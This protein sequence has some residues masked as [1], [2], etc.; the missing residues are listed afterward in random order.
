MKNRK[1]TYE[2]VLQQNNGYGWD[3]VEYFETNA[4]FGGLTQ[5]QWKNIKYLRAEYRIAQP[6]APTRLI[7]RRTKN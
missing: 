5:D 6:G 2:I 3:D 4:S 1:Y 7:H